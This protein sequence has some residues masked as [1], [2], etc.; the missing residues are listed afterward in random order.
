MQNQY[1]LFIKS[2]KENLV[3]GLVNFESVGR[4]VGAQVIDG[5]LVDGRW[6]YYKTQGN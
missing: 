3:R 1:F 2:L 5:Q 6:I 4:S